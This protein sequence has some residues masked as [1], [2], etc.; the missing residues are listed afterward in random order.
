MAGSIPLSGRRLQH[1]TTTAAAP[2]STSTVPIRI[3][4]RGSKM[5]TGSTPPALQSH[6]SSLLSFKPPHRL[7]GA[8]EEV[9][10]RLA[11]FQPHRRAEG[12]AAQQRHRQHLAPRQDAV[13][14]VDVDRDQLQVG[15]LLAEVVQAALELADL[16]ARVAGP[17]R[18]RRSA[19]NGVRSRGSSGRPGFGGP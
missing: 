11:G 13:H 17:P 16:V 3:S 8:G 1:Q 5:F 9:G 4:V 18:E 7:A 12:D 15:P 10:L 6:S 14:V 2:S 19:N